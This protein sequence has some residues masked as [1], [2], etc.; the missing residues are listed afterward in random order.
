M[1]AAEKH[2]G[3]YLAPVGIG[4]S[5]FIAEL[6]G[7]SHRTKFC[8]VAEL[9]VNSGVFFTGGSLNPARSFGPD[10]VNH[11][12][13]GYHWIYW[14]GPGL[15]S[16]LAVVFYRLIKILEFET[17][18]PGQDFDDKEN[19]LFQP[20]EA[21]TAADVRRPNVATGEP[22]YVTDGSG[23]Y[24]SPSRSRGGDSSR[25]PGSQSQRGPDGNI[26]AAFDSSATS[27]SHKRGR[28][29]IEQPATGDPTNTTQ[30]YS[31]NQTYQ[32]APS[33]ELGALPGRL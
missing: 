29:S 19:E 20:D 30:N 22:D 2:K 33:A 6:A 31:N 16:L 28:S 8:T 32:V 7:K 26:A 9:I 27:A 21:V 15:G 14:V 5:L 25:R 10:V 4:L 18:N 24:M 13:D 12:F 23:T 11:T 1:L 17:A 3:T